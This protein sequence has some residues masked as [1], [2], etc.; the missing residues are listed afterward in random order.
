MRD[1]VLMSD[2]RVG[3]IPVE[4]C[5]EPLHDVRGRLRMDDRLRDHEGAYAQLR[6]GLLDRLLQAQ[7]L[8]PDGY[9]LLVVEGFRPK[10][11]QRKYFDEYASELRAAHRD[12]SEE[13]LRVAASRYVAPIEVA[14]HIA[15]AAVDLT[16]CTEDGE[17]LDLGTP[18]NATPE[19]SAGRC[20]TAAEGIGAEATHNRRIMAAALEP[21][22]LV[23]YPTEWWHWSYGDRYWAMSVGARA[24]IYDFAD[25]PA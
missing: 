15:G 8:L 3:A 17:E 19:A 4:E 14:P 11:L 23:N 5:G 21:A 20:Y 10:D 13:Q 12:W 7:R 25:Y 22:G 16:L 24:A 18:V 6:S 2:S 9:R 1:V